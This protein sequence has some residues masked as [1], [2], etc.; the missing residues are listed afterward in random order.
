LFDLWTTPVKQ[1]LKLLKG[2]LEKPL[3]SDWKIPL[4]HVEWKKLLVSEEFPDHVCRS[5]DLE[6][7]FKQCEDETFDA[8]R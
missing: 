2:Y 5:Q 1:D 4:S 8:I 3:D 7:P 6:L